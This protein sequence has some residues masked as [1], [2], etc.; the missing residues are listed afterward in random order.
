VSNFAAIETNEGLVFKLYKPSE[1][2]LNYLKKFDD[3]YRVKDYPR[4][5]KV[6][7]G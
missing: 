2:V 1:E 6:K 7:V 3:L 4:A 5:I